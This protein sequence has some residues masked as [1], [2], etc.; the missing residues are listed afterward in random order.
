M[1]IRGVPS[2]AADLSIGRRF[3]HDRHAA[4]SASGTHEP[5][6]QTRQREVRSARA[7][8]CVEIEL[9]AIDAS[10]DGLRAPAIAISA[11]RVHLPAKASRRPQCLH[12]HENESGTDARS[13]QA[14]R[15]RRFS[16]AEFET[17][18]KTQ[19]K[20]ISHVLL[21]LGW[22][23]KRIWSTTGQYHVAHALP[24]SNVRTI[25]RSSLTCAL[26]KG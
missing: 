5:R 19:G 23:R 20:Y 4:T 1:A 22:R 26:A 3:E 7:N 6:L 13:G 24:P 8:Q 2:S 16:M 21:E 15:D 25:I 9:L 17:A 11:P 12:F 18:L 14:F 10:A